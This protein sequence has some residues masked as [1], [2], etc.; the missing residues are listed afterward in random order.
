MSISVIIIE[1]RE[2]DMD[3]SNLMCVTPCGR[4]KEVSRMGLN[5]ES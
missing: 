3:V 5:E 1:I 4:R 2:L